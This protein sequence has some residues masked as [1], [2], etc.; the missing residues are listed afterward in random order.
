MAL[1][2]Y[3]AGDNATVGGDAYFGETSS[4][5]EN[6]TYPVGAGDYGYGYEEG[7]DNY[8]AG[9]GDKEKKEVHLYYGALSVAV[10]TLGL[11]LCVEECRHRIDHAAVGRPF[12]LS[13][14]DG[15]Y[16]ELATLGFVELAVHWLQTY[17]TAIDKEKKAVFA[18]VHFLL[19]Y[20]AVFNAFQAAILAFACGRVSRELWIKTE[21]LELDHYVEIRE[22][23]DRIHEKLYGADDPRS[24][25]SKKKSFA[26]SIRNFSGAYGSPNE[27]GLA[28]AK[29]ISLGA[30][31]TVIFPRLKAKY[32][33]LRV[34]VRF[35]ELR[36]HFLQSYNLPSKMK[37]SDYLVKSQENVLEHF[38]HVSHTTW[39]LLTAM[40]NIL[41]F[42]MGISADVSGDAETSGY[43]L[44]IIF[45]CVMAGFVA[46]SFFVYY[47]MESILK[48]LM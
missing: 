39:L 11:I 20:T 32:N 41:Y 26:N 43:S 15:V 31:Y 47:H 33:Q 19:F 38:V 46:V 18:D 2:D 48:K 13:V 25:F 40:C 37:V 6:K 34:Q 8:D 16:R 10:L 24:S 7:Y 4:L 45:F 35:H 1:L 42:L 30:I 27:G 28:S 9:Y 29:R 21:D 17:S 22:E 5:Y 12:F 44:S 3:L 23:F 36:V 14:L